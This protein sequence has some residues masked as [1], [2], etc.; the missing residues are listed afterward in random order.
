MQE[1]SRKEST[2]LVRLVLVCAAILV[3]LALALWLTASGVQA[4]E[5]ESGALTSFLQPHSEALYIFGTLLGAL[6]HYF[7]KRTRHQTS[8]GF[9]SYWFKDNPKNSSASGVALLL[10]MFGVLGSG[11][12]VGANPWFVLQAAVATGFGINSALNKGAPPTSVYNS[13]G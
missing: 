2:S 9:F 12:F 6:A 5:G 10:S 7:K 11:V 4:A 13:G 3:A 1:I 8:S